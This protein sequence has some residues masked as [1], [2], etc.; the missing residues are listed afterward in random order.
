MSKKF[1][2][3][4]S[5][6]YNTAILNHIIDKIRGSLSKYKQLKDS[7]FLSLDIFEVIRPYLVGQYS[8]PPLKGLSADEISQ[9]T[10]SFHFEMEFDQNYKLVT[11]PIQFRPHFDKIIKYT[12]KLILSLV[13]RVSSLKSGISI[14]GSTLTHEKVIGNYYRIDFIIQSQ[15]IILLI[16]VDPRCIPVL[17]VNQVRVFIHTQENLDDAT[18]SLLNV[19]TISKISIV[20]LIIKLGKTLFKYYVSNALYD[21]L[22][23]ELR[24]EMAPF[25]S[26]LPI[27]DMDKSLYYDIILPL[28]RPNVRISRICDLDF[29]ILD[30]YKKIIMVIGYSNT[31]NTSCQNYPHRTGFESNYHDET[32]YILIDPSDSI[33]QINHQSIPDSSFVYYCKFLPLCPDESDQTEYNDIVN[34][35]N[36]YFWEQERPEIIQRTISEDITK[37]GQLCGKYVSKL[38]IYDSMIFYGNFNLTCPK[39]FR[40]SIKQIGTINYTGYQC[41][42][43]KL[44]KIDKCD[45]II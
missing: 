22:Y 9:T 23:F 30:R 7:I 15:K 2:L 37:F 16:P 42:D 32:C 24:S 41:L 39:W 45:K 8:V 13:E 1:E 43:S 14:L 28:L 18:I 10:K 6:N 12:T 3:W 20:N 38:T 36:F 17:F 29:D 31:V 11:P 26:N 33:Y 5:Y 27:W 44:T 25:L 21:G 40:D 35:L 19:S 34:Y 4:E